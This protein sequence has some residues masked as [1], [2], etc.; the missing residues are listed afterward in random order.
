MTLRRLRRYVL[1]TMRPQRSSVP[2]GRREWAWIV[3]AVIVVL[4]VAAATVYWR[5]GEGRKPLAETAASPDPGIRAER[6]KTLQKTN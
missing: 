4:G 6:L 2:A 5:T 1:A 3:L